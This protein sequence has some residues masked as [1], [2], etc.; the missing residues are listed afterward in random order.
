MDRMGAAERSPTEMFRL[1]I[2]TSNYPTPA[3]P[4]YGTFVRQFAHALARQ[5]VGC[6]VIQ[7]VAVHEERGRFGLADCEREDAGG[8]Q[9]VV[10]HRPRFLSLSAREAF[11]RL[12]P[13]NPSR[14]TLN[15]FA[16]AVRR[17]LRGQRIRPDA[18]YG[19][20]LYLAGAAA[21]RVGR[22]LGIPA[23]P[24]VGEGEL[25]TVRQFGIAHARKALAGACGFL[26]NSSALRETLVRRLGFSGDRIGVFPNGTNLAAFKPLDRSAARTR[27]GLPQDRFLVAA[28]GN[29]LEKKGIARVGAAIEGLAGVAGV[30]AGSGPVP[31]TASNVAL[32]RRVAHEDM[33][34]LLS[35]CDVFVL[36]TLV[37][38]SCNA[39]VEAM[40]CGLPIVSSVGAFNDDVLDESMSIRVDPLDVPAIR[41]AIVRL[42]DD[43][44]LRARM[45]AAAL[46]R[47]RLFDVDDR[48]RRMVA[49]IRQRIESSGGPAAACRSCDSTGNEIQQPTSGC[50]WRGSV[51]R[52]HGN[53]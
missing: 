40:A 2:V 22:E 29:F 26:A 43:P 14:F 7:P 36:P 10:V 1:A 28:A 33:P 6:A 4:T 11:V 5:G 16:A 41:Q 21:V 15:R 12:G 18:L 24:C 31:P 13:F 46:R 44:A 3:R 38:G 53:V 19:H 50:A 37:E 32:C 8:G 49:F 20:F 42:R 9:T 25:W 34:V 51:G 30:F 35:A 27:L 23:F 52:L 45:A 17:T 48:A 47:S 39:L